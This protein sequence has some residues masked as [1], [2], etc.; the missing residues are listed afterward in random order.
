[1]SCGAASGCDTI[2]AWE[3]AT[4][5]ILAFAPIF[6]NTTPV[7]DFRGFRVRCRRSRSPAALDRIIHGVTSHL[8]RFGQ[9]NELH[10]EWRRP[11]S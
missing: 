4:S 2:E 5:W 6:L 8:E 9:R 1:M 3:A 10:V 11:A 7:A